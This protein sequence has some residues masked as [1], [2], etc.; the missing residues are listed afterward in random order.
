MNTAFIILFAIFVLVNV[1]LGISGRIL[2]NKQTKLE[3]ERA[4]HQANW[5]KQVNAL[6]LKCYEVQSENLRLANDRNDWIKN[7]NKMSVAYN[8]MQ[9]ERD[10][11]KKELEVLKKKK[12][13]KKES[14]ENPPQEI[15]N[16]S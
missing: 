15:E 3:N 7:Y 9:K 16:K 1:Y 11:L 12:S 8:D 10:E 6:S 14:I 13:I 5:D 4:E 2:N